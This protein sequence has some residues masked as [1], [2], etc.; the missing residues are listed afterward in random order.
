MDDKGLPGMT[1]CCRTEGTRSRRRQTKTWTDNV[2]QDPVENGMDI[3]M[4]MDT[5]ETEG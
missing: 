1:L 4:S 5:T 3:R 2:R